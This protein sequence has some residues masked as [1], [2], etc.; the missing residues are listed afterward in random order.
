MELALLP[1]QFEVVL[2]KIPKHVQN[3][4]ASSTAIDYEDDYCEDDCCG[5]CLYSQE[6]IPR[7]FRLVLLRIILHY[8]NYTRKIKFYK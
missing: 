7:M 8:I 6:V 4:S 2:R 3:F 5:T 1:A